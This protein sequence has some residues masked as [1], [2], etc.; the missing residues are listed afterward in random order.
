MLLSANRPKLPT[1][2]P[3]TDSPNDTITGNQIAMSNQ[4][5]RA[6]EL[7]TRIFDAP[8][9]LGSFTGDLRPAGRTQRGSTGGTAH[10]AT[11]LPQGDS[12]RV[13]G[14]LVAGFDMVKDLFGKQ[15][16]VGSWLLFH[17]SMMALSEGRPQGKNA[18]ISN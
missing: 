2:W 13:L 10:L 18:W 14:S 6:Q 12:R 7:L 4:K 8:S 1:D 16:R 9:P 15:N 5:M 3:V 11:K 17:A